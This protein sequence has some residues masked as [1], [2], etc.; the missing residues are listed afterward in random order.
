VKEHKGAPKEHK[1]AMK[2]QKRAAKEQERAAKSSFARVIR[3]KVKDSELGRTS[4]NPP[5]NRNCLDGRAWQL[6][7]RR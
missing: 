7:R 3:V 5:I 2:E 4:R 6:F 1:G